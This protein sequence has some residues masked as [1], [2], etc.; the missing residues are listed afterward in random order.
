MRHAANN[1]KLDEVVALIAA[2]NADKV[3]YEC[4]IENR[5]E[6]M[7]VAFPDDARVSIGI[8]SHAFYVD[9][10]QPIETLYPGGTN[11]HF[12]MGFDTFER[13]LD[14]EGRYLARYHH[15]FAG[16][17]A[18][19]EFLL[20]RSRLIVAGRGDSGRAEVERLLKQQRADLCDR[21]YFANC[22]ADLAERSA[23]EVRERIRGRQS[24]EGLVEPAVRRYIE[25]NGL[26]S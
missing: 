19:V 13:V 3:S 7:L 23:T 2:S 22:P 20:R 15:R 12:I 16:A 18:A 21:V 8:G 17:D 14:S 11:L 25:Q 9:M 26:Y 1:F 6:M 10:V 5:I 4:P 24:I